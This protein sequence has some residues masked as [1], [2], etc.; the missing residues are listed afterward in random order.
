MVVE[1]NIRRFTMA[2]IPSENK[3]PLLVDTDTAKAFE[4]APQFFEMIA[5]R[6]SQILIRRRIVDHLELAK[7]S[8]IQIGRYFLRVY[9][10]D[11]EITQPIISKAYDHSPSPILS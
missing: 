6:D 3:P 11:E 1:I 7:Q 10:I 8:A 4:I 5:G 2:A 9:I